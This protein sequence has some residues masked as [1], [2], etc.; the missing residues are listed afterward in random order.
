[1]GQLAVAVR[2]ENQ[3]PDCG[4]AEARWRSSSKLPS[5]AH[6][7]SSRTR[8]TGWRPSRG[9]QT[10]HGSEEQEPFGVGVGGLARG[11]SRMRLAQGRN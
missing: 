4:S 10:H 11:R 5:S 2:A 8:T 1:M 3:Y 7:R 6:C 9:Q